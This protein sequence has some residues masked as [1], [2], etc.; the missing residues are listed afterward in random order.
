MNEQRE[1][2]V[3]TS[4]EYSDYGICGVFDDRTLADAFAEKCSGT[5][6]E[7]GVEVWPLNP[8][9]DD[10]RA[11]HD[12][13]FVR[14]KRTGD[15]MEARRVDAGSRAVGAVMALD[16]NGDGF[17]TCFARDE[18]HAVKIANERRAQ[19]IASGGW[20]EA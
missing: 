5:Y 2:Y 8:H 19:L 13:Y 6:A 11:G 15:T 1:I 10:L 3:V 20:P 9:A 18:Q 4:G 7:A 17:T 16:V 12:P 14:M